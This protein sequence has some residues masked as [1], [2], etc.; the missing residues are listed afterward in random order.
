MAANVEMDQSEMLARQNRQDAE[1]EEEQKL[2]PL[3]GPME[4]PECLRSMYEGAAKEGFLKAID[5]LCKSYKMRRV[6][7][8]GNCFYRALLFGYLDQL[9]VKLSS[10]D[11][12][13]AGKVELER[14]LTTIKGSMND[15]VQ[16][17]YN[18]FAIETFYD[19]FIELLEGLPNMSRE[20]L[21][22][23]F[24]EGGSGDH[25]TWYMRAMTAGY[26]K[27]HPDDFFP[28]IVAE[29]TYSDIAT[30]CEKEVEPMGKECEQVQITALTTYLKIQVGIIY[31]D[32]S[33]ADGDDLTTH[34]FPGE[35]SVGIVPV[36]LLYRPGHYDLLSA[37]SD[38]ES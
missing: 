16:V 19:M 35:S 22:E 8:D 31:V 4:G 26:M 14:M 37:C 10:S 33:Q 20:N 24:Q 38:T 15:L 13:E 30:F 23:E 25:Y 17:G 1:I 18:E 32:G 29:G 36:I 2:I 3:M 21:L 34:A 12:K 28:F 6:R 27:S 7:G 5:L 9:L 11:T